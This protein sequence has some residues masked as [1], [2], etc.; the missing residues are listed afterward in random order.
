MPESV[1]A[2]V[3][4]WAVRLAKTRTQATDACKAGHVRVRGERA[5]P[6]TPVRVGDTVIV[7]T[8]ERERIVVATK[9]VLKRV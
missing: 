2:D 5:K 6:S 8:H 4:V 7:R 3:W 1:R 9:L